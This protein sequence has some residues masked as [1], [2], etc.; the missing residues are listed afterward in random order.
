M[1]RAC[2]LFLC[3]A[4]A[5]CSE[6]PA[7]LAPDLAVDFGCA[8]NPRPQAILAF[9]SAHGFSSIDEEQARHRKGRTFFPLQIDA[10]DRR[11]V[12]IEVIGL[13]KPK[14]YGSGIDYRLTITSPPPTL[15]DQA[16]E[17]D[18]VSLVRGTLRCDLHAVSRFENGRDSL[19]LFNA[20]FEDE[21]RR[22]R[23]AHK[24]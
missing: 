8:A 19:E 1:K 17:S 9:L 14:S 6:K 2:A 10:F 21:Q 5:A 4:L 23:A 3:T 22:M 15:H 16:L 7:V 24:M 11:R 18:A 20:I 12:L 13:K